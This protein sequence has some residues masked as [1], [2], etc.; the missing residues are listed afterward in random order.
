MNSDIFKSTIGFVY[1][2]LFLMRCMYGIIMELMFVPISCIRLIFICCTRESQY[3]CFKSRY[4]DSSKKFINVN[5]VYVEKLRRMRNRASR[6]MLRT[7]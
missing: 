6:L 5:G 4:S 7:Q 2:H 1:G 3:V